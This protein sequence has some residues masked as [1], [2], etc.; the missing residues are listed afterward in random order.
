MSISRIQELFPYSAWPYPFQP[1]KRN[2]LQSSSTN[3]PA[4]QRAAHRTS[5][6][7]H[8]PLQH[9]KALQWTT[10]ALQAKLTHTPCW[11][12]PSAAPS[13]LTVLHTRTLPRVCLA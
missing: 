13:V 9:S 3:L 11:A 1:V 5:P 10:Q 8:I 7:M 2:S 12:G 6:Y 4:Q